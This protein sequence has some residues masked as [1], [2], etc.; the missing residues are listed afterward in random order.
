MKSTITF[1]G[2]ALLTVSS[3][4]AN[5]LLV[6]QEMQQE[7]ATIVVTNQQSDSTGASTISL[8]TMEDA[9]SGDSAFFNPESVLKV[10]YSK[11]IDQVVKEDML[12]TE[13]Q[14][15]VYQ[16]LCIE[17]SVQDKIQEDNQ[18]IESNISE[19][20]FPLDFEKINR[21]AAYIKVDLNNTAIPVDIKL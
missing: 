3:V 7:T 8:Q 5:E 6:Q 14:E 17:M 21:K 19:E 13:A 15:E 4:K 16:P 9:N 20:V 1:L 18:I 10:S 2:L 11:P 12:V